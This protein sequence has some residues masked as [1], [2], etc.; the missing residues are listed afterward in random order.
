[1]TKLI[2]TV[3]LG[4]VAGAA[5]AQEQP[6]VFNTDRTI[7]GFQV[8]VQP[9]E[10]RP[11]YALEGKGLHSAVPVG[12]PGTDCVINPVSLRTAFTEVTKTELVAGQIIEIPVNVLFDFD[13]DIVR[14]EGVD[15]LGEFYSALVDNEV[16]SIEIVGHTD[17][18]GTDEYNL[19]L[20]FRR[21][22][23]VASALVAAG[24]D[25]GNIEIDSAGEFEPKVPNTFEDG[26]DNP[27]NRQ[28]NRRV[29]VK[30]T[31]M[32]DQEVEVVEVVEVRKNP[33]IFHVLGS[34]NSVR[35]MGTQPQIGIN[36]G[37]NLNPNGG[38]VI[39]VPQR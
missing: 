39:T 16:E 33:Q 34:N 26:T 22:A 23:A 10:M 12:R 6:E 32:F 36:V 27:D 38:V 35:C 25:A 1:M 8:P 15:A 24:F 31:K 2:T 28:I 9:P 13:G 37:G 4:L 30:I 17:S 20:G 19:D 11:G 29:D 7:T 5:I 21:A 18:K 3:L 14:P